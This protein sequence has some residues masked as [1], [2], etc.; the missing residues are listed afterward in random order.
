MSGVRFSN[1]PGSKKPSKKKGNLK[2]T[3]TRVLLDGPSVDIRAGRSCGGMHTVVQPGEKVFRN[4]KLLQ[5]PFF[6]PKQ[7]MKKR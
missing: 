2:E 1:V 4:Q 5:T 7:L 6:V 3:N